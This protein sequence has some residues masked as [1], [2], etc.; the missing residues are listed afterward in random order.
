MVADAKV[1]ISKQEPYQ[2]RDFSAEVGNYLK[3]KLKEG[4]LN[5]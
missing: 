1:I 3:V 2:E 4:L 5:D